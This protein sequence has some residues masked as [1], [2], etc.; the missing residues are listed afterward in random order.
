MAQSGPLPGCA[1]AA[2]PDQESGADVTGRFFYLVSEQVETVVAGI[3]NNSALKAIV[4]KLVQSDWEKKKQHWPHALLPL[5]TCQ[6]V[7]GPVEAAVHLTCA[8]NLLHLAAHV[9]DDVEDEGCFVGLDGPIPLGETI[10]LGT[11]L[12]FLA[13]LAFDRLS[14]TGVPL[15]LAWRVRHELHQV[16]TRMGAGQHQDLAVMASSEPDLATYWQVIGDKTGCFFGWAAQSGALIGGGSDS[17][18]EDCYTYGYNM[19]LLL[20]I[21]DDWTGLSSNE[22]SSDLAQGKKTL[23]VLYALAVAPAWQKEQLKILLE[24]AHFQSDAES[25]IR[26]EI[27][28][29]GGLHYTLIQAE[30]RRKRAET[31]LLNLPGSES[32][33][34]LL[35]L[36]DQA[37]P[38]R[39]GSHRL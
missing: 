3:H 33:D 13:Q 24:E 9:L 7:G 32:R 22:G 8:W 16:I 23:P 29:L 38:I 31:A 37:F 19:G 15:S 6:L 20:Q 34:C 4:E 26:E 36:L 28:R 10:N 27:V 18:V 21:L 2:N 1:G 35:M 17:Q 39:P 25:K 12:I 30:I 14:D 5:L 11:S